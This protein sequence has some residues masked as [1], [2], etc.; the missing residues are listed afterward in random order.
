MRKRVRL[1]NQNAKTIGFFSLVCLVVANMIGSGL[2]TSSGFALSS[3]GRADLVMWVWAVGGI[4]A[5]CGAIA[6]GAIAKRLPDSGGEYLY[7][8]RLIHPS[9]GF[10]AAGFR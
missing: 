8:S 1:N 5:L 3:L 10:L 7:L 4:M 9:V 6:Y 2:Y